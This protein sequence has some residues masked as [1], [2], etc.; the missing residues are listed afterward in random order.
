[1]LRHETMRMLNMVFEGTRDVQ[2]LREPKE[3]KSFISYMIGCFV[4]H[5]WVS[6]AVQLTNQSLTLLPRL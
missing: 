3:T 1:M 6:G 2:V 4:L 5:M